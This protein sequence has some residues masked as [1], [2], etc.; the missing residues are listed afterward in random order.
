[1]EP[2]HR[3]AIAGLLVVLVTVGLFAAFRAGEIA[4]TSG[5][6]PIVITGAPSQ[7]P[8]APIAAAPPTPAPESPQKPR[9]SHRHHAE[10][11]AGS[12]D[13]GTGEAQS[14][15]HRRSGSV[16]KL[17][18]PGDGSVDMNT[19]SAEELQRLP[20]VG[21]KMAA[22]ILEY[23]DQIG[24]FHSPEDLTNVPGIGDKKLAK[25]RPFLRF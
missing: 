11:T 5:N 17:K 7:Q 2:R 20:G 3:Y 22:K 13:V 4:G 23:R 18:E 8:P 25:M 24:G 16:A 19:A 12:E 14:E 6:V 1:M 10:E 9:K 21:P 15:R